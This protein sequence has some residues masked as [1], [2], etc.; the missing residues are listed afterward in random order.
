MIEEF[1][2][3]AIGRII[4]KSGQGAEFRLKTL[5]K[6]EIRKAGAEASQEKMKRKKNLKQR[7]HPPRNQFLSS[8]LAQILAVPLHRV[9][10]AVIMIQIKNL[11]GICTNATIAVKS[12][13]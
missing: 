12:K 13:S 4:T 2:F 10:Q 1:R 7:S 3:W 5:I 11:R 6:G 9:A 8:P